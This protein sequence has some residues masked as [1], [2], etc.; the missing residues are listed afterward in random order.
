[1]APQHTDL[2]NALRFV[3][4]H[5]AWIRY[6]TARGKWLVWDDNRRRWDDFE[7]VVASAQ[8]TVEAMVSDAMTENNHQQR[9]SSEARHQLWSTCSNWFKLESHIRAHRR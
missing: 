6:C 2:S 3:A 5:G 1:L 7:A 4:D 8:E 9:L